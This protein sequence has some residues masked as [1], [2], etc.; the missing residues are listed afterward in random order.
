MVLLYI[1]NKKVLTKLI[2]YLELEHIPYTTSLEDSYDT[3]I[4]IEPIKK[5]F[6]FIKQKKKIIF[7]TELEEEKIAKN[8]H[9]DS[10]V[11][12]D[13]QT[14]LIKIFNSCYRVIVTTEYYK[15]LLKKYTKTDIVVIP[16]SLPFISLSK[17]NKEIYEIYPIHKRK[18]KILI[19]DFSYNHLDTIYSLVMKHPEYQYVYIGYESRYN[20]AKKQKEVLDKMP[21][22]VLFIKYTDFNFYSSLVKTATMVIL[23]DSIDIDY[24]YIPMYLKKHLLMSEPNIYQDTYINSKHVYTFE[25]ESEFYLKFEKILE[26]RLSNLTEEAYLKIKDNNFTNIA[27]QYRIYLE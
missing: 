1:E 8:F 12:K 3:V 20:M 17:H 6:D 25:D 9:K 7:I 14:K 15:N 21:T 4:L 18:K 19:V 24:L 2:F 22:S 26:N 10:K 27:K 13:Y 11:T 16:K 5:I 23:F